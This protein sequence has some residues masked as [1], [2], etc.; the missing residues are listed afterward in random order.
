[1]RFVARF[2]VDV[3]VTSSL[4]ETSRPHNAQP[5]HSDI[6][7]VLEDDGYDRLGLAA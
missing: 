7:V 5:L 6:H 3:D 1:M 4:D 2:V